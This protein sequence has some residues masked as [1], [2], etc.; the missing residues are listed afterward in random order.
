MGGM[1][2]SS[3]S[4]DLLERFLAFC[5]DHRGVGESVQASHRR[6]LGRLFSFLRSRRVV[7]ARRIT[8]SLL[9]VFLLKAAAGISSPSLNGATSALRQFLRFL[10]QEN[11]L[12]RALA[13]AVAKPRQFRGEHRPKYIPWPQV[14]ELLRGVDRRTVVGKR[15]FAILTLMAYQGLRAQEVGRLRMDDVRWESRSVFLRRRKTGRPGHL[16][17]TPITLEAIK[18]YLAVR[19]SV[20]FPEIFVTVQGPPRPL[21]R[22]TYSVARREIE[23]AFGGQVTPAGSHTLRHSFAKMLLDNGAPLAQIGQLMGHARIQS[24]MSYLRVATEDLREVADNYA[25]FL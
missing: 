1:D 13:D 5:R 22:F 17:L 23:R 4:E 24:T 15:A 20:N 3:L 11:L 9:D 12:P 21:G 14:E 25:D 7:Q 10:F 16:P 18:D 2:R 6:W 19:P 8:V